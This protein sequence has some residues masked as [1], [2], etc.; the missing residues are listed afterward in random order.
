MWVFVGGSKEEEEEEEELGKVPYKM[1][2]IV[3]RSKEPP[4]TRDMKT[5]CLLSKPTWFIKVAM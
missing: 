5:D 1:A 3:P 2:G 4:P